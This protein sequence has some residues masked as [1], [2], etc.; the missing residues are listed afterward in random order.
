MSIKCFECENVAKHNHHVVPKIYGG[1]K[2]VPL[3]E[4]CHGKVHG[5][6]FEGHGELI[7]AGLRNAKERGVSLGRPK[8]STEDNKRYL[9][10]YKDVVESLNNGMSIRKAAKKHRI[11]TSTVQ[12]VKKQINILADGPAPAK[13]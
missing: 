1:T 7:K 12:R 3:C 8:G 4:L 6:H 2:T 5:L 9:E 13:G 10:K 11:G